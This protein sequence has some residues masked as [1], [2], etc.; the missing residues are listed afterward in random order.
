M[1]LHESS[2]AFDKE[3]LEGYNKS[4]MSQIYF[5]MVQSQT[6]QELLSQ[7]EDMIQKIENFKKE[8]NSYI[9]RYEANEKQN[10]KLI[11]QIESYKNLFH[12]YDSKIKILE[13][14]LQKYIVDDVIGDNGSASLSDSQIHDQS[15]DPYSAS[16]DAGFSSFEE[17][18]DTIV[19]LKF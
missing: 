5:N 10:S 8:L 14:R 6:Y 9:R 3:L 16:E 15:F 4:L 12:S 13:D 18:P 19:R 2:P 17:Q 1:N 11:A 7:N